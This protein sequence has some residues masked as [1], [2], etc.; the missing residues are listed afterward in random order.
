MT[1]R[2][3]RINSWGPR[4]FLSNARFCI[5]DS[6][7]ISIRLSTEESHYIRDVLRLKIGDPLEVGIA[8]DS[9]N[10]RST[11]IGKATVAS[12][13][14]CVTVSVSETKYDL[15]SPL[16]QISVLCALCKGEK[17]EL[18]IDW[19]TELGCQKIYF[20]QS[21]RS[22][23]RLKNQ[24]D[25]ARK[26]LRFN[27]IAQSAAQQ[28]KQNHLL[29]VAVHP[30][31][32]SAVKSLPHI[33]TEMKLVCSM[34]TEAKPIQQVIKPHSSDSPI[35]LAIGPEGDFAPDEERLLCSTNL[36]SPISLG[37]ATLRSELALVMA[38]A[39]IRHHDFSSGD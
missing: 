34:S 27:K 32:E 12:T 2:Y 3:S 20:W 14:G 35:L 5:S 7:P 25:I 21:D 18:M 4:L 22:V 17:N 28:S 30:D 26:T 39:A 13:E 6:L 10:I 24:D 31:I 37:P 23:V 36:F 8:T 16:R 33:S 1:A 19:A 38:I 15:S 11:I 9:A 29:T